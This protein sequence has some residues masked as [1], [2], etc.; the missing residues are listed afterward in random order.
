MKNRAKL[1][2][3]HIFLKAGSARSKLLDEVFFV[4]DVARYFSSEEFENIITPYIDND[5]LYFV[6]VRMFFEDGSSMDTPIA[7]YLGDMEISAI[8]YRAL[9]DATD[10]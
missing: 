4:C 7:H 6:W 1:K 8:A 9:Y 2:R 5:A 10:R 3:I